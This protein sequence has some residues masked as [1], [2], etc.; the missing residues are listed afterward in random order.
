MLLV[1]PCPQ[2][3]VALAREVDLVPSWNHGMADMCELAAFS[4]TEIMVSECWGFMAP[5]TGVERCE[6]ECCSGASILSAFVCLTVCEAANTSA[7]AAA[8]AAG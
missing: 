7:L 3:V 8:M 2:V 4:P 1:L 5:L 6:Y